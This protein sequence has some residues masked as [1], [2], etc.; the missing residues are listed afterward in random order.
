M[1]YILR[2]LLNWKKVL[3]EILIIK[4]TLFHFFIEQKPLTKRFKRFGLFKNKTI[5]NLNLS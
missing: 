3:V 4:Q 5:K 1:F 2:S